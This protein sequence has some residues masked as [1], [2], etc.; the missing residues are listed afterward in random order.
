MQARLN[1]TTLSRSAAVESALREWQRGLE[2]NFAGVIIHLET[3]HHHPKIDA[4]E[5]FGTRRPPVGGAFLGKKGEHQEGRVVLR[6]GCHHLPVAVFALNAR[7]HEIVFFVDLE[8]PIF[9]PK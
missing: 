2:M 4:G 6:C 5:Q 1:I 3:P 8:F 9:S 7:A